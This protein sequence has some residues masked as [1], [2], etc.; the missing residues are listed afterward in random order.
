VNGGELQQM[1]QRVE[2]E[3]R[4]QLKKLK[5]LLKNYDKDTIEED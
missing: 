3:F 4:L 2:E 5:M 1:K